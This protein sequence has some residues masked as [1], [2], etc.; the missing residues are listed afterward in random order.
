MAAVRRF[1]AV[2]VGG[3]CAC[4]AAPGRA[5]YAHEHGGRFIAQRA[6]AAQL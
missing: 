5:A 2:P 3:R 4:S 6:L 1:G